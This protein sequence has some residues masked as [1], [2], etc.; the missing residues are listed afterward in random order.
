MVGKSIRSALQQILRALCSTV[1]LCA[2][3][4]HL[5]ARG[6]RS[7]ANVGSKCPARGPRVKCSA[8]SHA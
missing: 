7:K 8:C 4:L 1:F 2:S 6:D 5:A 3:G